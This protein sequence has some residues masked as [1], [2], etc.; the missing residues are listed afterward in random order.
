MPD[1][2]ELEEE[3]DVEWEKDEGSKEAP[4]RRVPVKKYK[5]T[6]IPC[7][8]AGHTHTLKIKIDS[9]GKVSG[10][11]FCPLT[12]TMMKVTKNKRGIIQATIA[13]V[14]DFSYGKGVRSRLGEAA[15]F[16]FLAMVFAIGTPAIGILGIPSLRPWYIVAALILW[17]AHVLLPSQSEILKAA[18]KKEGE[19]T[20]TNEHMG[21]AYSKSFLKIFSMIFLVLEFLPIPFASIHNNLL[22]TIILLIEYF[23][24]PSSYFTNQPTKASEAWL[25]TFLGV[26]LSTSFFFLF[27]PNFDLGNTGL[28]IGL[29]YAAVFVGAMITINIVV[30]KT[31]ATLLAGIVLAV[32]GIPIA[33]TTAPS[34]LAP[35]F[36]LFF[37]SMAFFVVFPTR[38]KPADEKV[39]VNVGLG[40]GIH[41]YI[42]DN[43]DKWEDLGKGV[44]LGF[45]LAA[46]VPVI[47]GLIGVPGVPGQ[48]TLI[49]T[50]IWAIAIG[51][52]TTTGREGRPYLGIMILAFSMFAFSLS[53]SETIGVAFFGSYYGPVSNFFSTTLGPVGDAFGKTSC[54]A[55]ASYK[56]I[57]EGPATCAAER[58]RC[59]KR[60][61]TAEGSIQAIE[62]VTVNFQP[63]EASNSIPTI[64]Y[65]EIENKG[66]WDAK[67][68][69]LSVE[70][71][72]LKRPG[73]PSKSA[74][75]FIGNSV[76]NSCIGGDPTQDKKGCTYGGILP[77]LNKA[78]GRGGKGAMQFTLDWNSLTNSDRG[79]SPDV[80]FVIKYNYNVSSAYSIDA[81]SK[82]EIK[83]L[84]Q[85]GQTIG[86]TIARY[87]GGPIQASLWTP[88]YVQENTPVS[89]TG[90]LT[91]TGSGT[92]SKST[93]CIYLPNDVDTIK[94]N[95]LKWSKNVAETPDKNLCPDIPN[96][97]TIQC[98]L[99]AIE[100][101]GTA[102]SNLVL[103]DF[104]SC[105]L[106]IE[107]HTN[108]QPQKR[109]DIIGTASY[110][111][112]IEKVK[113]D[114]IVSALSAEQAGTAASE[115]PTS[116]T[117]P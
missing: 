91:N 53:Y 71:P 114:I 77:K 78:T 109:L 65:I 30:K 75:A 84:L 37:L 32:I 10:G 23:S 43:Y 48:L 82:D 25:R 89:I 117:P 69:V 80:T 87:S 94:N 47:G 105:S 102:D 2:V 107:A 20:F 45:A 4:G 41:E 42:N 33:L 11:P 19:V 35:N 110:D 3:P 101:A 50:L 113:K 111:Y 1:D 52:G 83:R 26:F 22:A 112:T 18:R 106:W 6:K 55:A 88:T 104:R 103:Q 66:D 27:T 58:L 38:K 44:F 9:N 14:A 81:R 116:P 60:E 79:L 46:A 72:R 54:E 24:L 34:L 13:S 39:T 31:W 108:G 74:G 92:A 59:Q 49:M 16:F 90:T 67:D 7:P 63:K 29:I 86:T 97:K 96:T 51:I 5:V 62:V 70:D 99:D 17:G 85:E 115:E 100:K 76:I 8:I 15:I 56:C 40:Q 57:T 98:N 68:V 61:S 12:G 21:L 28:A 64:G 73:T 36:S 95:D 93:Y